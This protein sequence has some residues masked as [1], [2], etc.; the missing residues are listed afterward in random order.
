MRRAVF[1]DRDGILNV[2]RG[3]VFRPDDFEWISGAIEAIRRINAAGY[4]AIVATNQSGIARQYYTQS[5]FTALT[6]WMQRELAARGAKLD[7]I[8]HCPHHVEGS[9]PVLAVACDC[10]KP[11]PGLLLRAMAEFDIDPKQSFLVGDKLQD[12]EA[13]QAAG[14]SGY[15]FEGGNLDTFIAPLLAKR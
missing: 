14:V 6:D 12:M 11:K 9:D 15:L 13:A 3:Y 4:L 7:A 1:L 2:D 10:R 8:Y 5:D